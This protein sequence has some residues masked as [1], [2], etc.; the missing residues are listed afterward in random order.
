MITV[1]E[2]K[3]IL[4]DMNIPDDAVVLIEADHGQNTE[5]M[6]SLVATR[7]DPRKAYDF[8]DMIF[9]YDNWKDVYDEDAV[10]EYDVSR[11]ICGVLI[12]SY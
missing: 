11:P 4:S 3:G 6:I 8:G 10:E 9:E 1:G 5:S 12:S 2:L 7:D